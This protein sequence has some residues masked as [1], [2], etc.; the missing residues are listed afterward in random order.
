M[1]LQL[2]ETNQHA[3]ELFAET[4]LS[5]PMPKEVLVQVIHGLIDH[6]WLDDELRDH[7]VLAAANNLGI[8]IIGN[9]E[10]GA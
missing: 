4:I 5:K 2:A 1:Q 10:D 8:E 3:A 6:P 7:L 9:E